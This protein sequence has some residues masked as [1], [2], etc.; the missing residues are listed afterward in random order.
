MLWPNQ[1]TFLQRSV[2]HSVDCSFLKSS[3]ESFLGPDGLTYWDSRTSV[4]DDGEG[5]GLA[6]RVL[7]SMMSGGRGCGS[8]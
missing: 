6:R 2:S 1:R 7:C 4:D 5:V 8:G 3:I